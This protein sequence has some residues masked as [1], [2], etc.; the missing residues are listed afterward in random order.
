MAAFDL[1][2]QEQIDGLKAWWNDNGNWVLGSVLFV[3]I[4]MGGWR[5]WH[6]YQAKQANEA[7]NMFEQFTEQVV[8]NDPKRINDAAAVMMDKYARTVYA[9]RAALAAAPTASPIPCWDWASCMWPGSCRGCWALVRDPSRS[10][11]W[12][13]PCDSPSRSPAPPATL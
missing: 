8:S 10:P 12:I 1:Q 11:P 3:V 2:E 13:W 9:S 4:A 7:A 5:G 6:Y